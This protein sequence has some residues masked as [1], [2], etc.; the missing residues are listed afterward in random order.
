MMRE[1][2]GDGIAN[3]RR[4]FV[5]NALLC[6]GALVAPTA[7]WAR[8]SSDPCDAF[9][10]NVHD[11]GAVGDGV[12]DDT[13]AFQ[14]A[15][16]ALPSSGG[17]VLVPAGHYLIDAARSIRLR[18]RTRLL[19]SDAAELRAIPNDLPRA[20]VLLVRDVQDVTIRGGR[21]V[22][23][24]GAHLGTAG[25][26]GYGIFVWGAQ[27]VSVSDI[28]ISECWGDGICIGSIFEHGVLTSVASDVQL[29]RVVCAA[30]RR[31]GLSIT[32]AR[33][34][35]VVDSRFIDT[36]GTLPGCGID[37]EPGTPKMGAQDV[38][39]SGCTVTGNQG[40]GIQLYQHIEHVRLEH[41]TISDN[42]G[43]GV[44]LDG[45]SQ[46]VIQQNVISGNGLTGAVLGNDVSYCRVVDNTFSHNGGRQL[47]R[48]LKRIGRMVSNGSPT[49]GDSDLRIHA[50]GE[51]IVESGNIFV[52]RPASWPRR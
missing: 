6:L 7:A 8:L 2:T 29:T 44:L 34:I 31:Q 37:V 25:E 30:N 35:K 10:V 38:L 36:G 12:H 21:I 23:E 3:S 24:R 16:D 19:L 18:S 13:T 14:A 43:Y 33:R 28:H 4:H 42:H 40:S 32:S 51:G 20:Y 46:C 47:H 17:T 45:V 1:D 48:L 52:D 41:C 26:W 9:L 39:I 15:I 49:A 22:G 5:R 11:K 27:R 50:S